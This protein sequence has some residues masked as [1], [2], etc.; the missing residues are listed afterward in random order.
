MRVPKICLGGHKLKMMEVQFDEK[1]RSC[2]LSVLSA[3]RNGLHDLVYFYFNKR[4]ST[5]KRLVFLA[6]QRFTVS[7]RLYVRLCVVSEV[8]YMTNLSIFVFIIEDVLY[9]SIVN[10]VRHVLCE[11]FFRQNCNIIN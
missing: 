3:S 5:P 1:T 7:V 9:T 2:S 6:F 8:M 10:R 11:I 4:Y